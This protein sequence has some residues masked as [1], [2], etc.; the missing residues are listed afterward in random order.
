MKIVDILKQ[1][2]K[3]LSFEVF[4]PKRESSF[5]S[6][7]LATERIAK[8]RPAFMSVTYGA[9]GGVSQYTI[10][11]AKN[12]KEKYQ[13][14]MLA[15]LTCVA[16]SH[17]SVAQK[18]E[19]MYQAGI[20]N[21]MALRGDLT[22]DLMKQDPSK[23]EYTHAVELV[24]QLKESKHDFCIGGACYPEK[25]PESKSR[26]DDLKY[27]KEKADAG[28]DFFTTQ[29][30]FDNEIFYDFLNKATGAGIKI[31]ILPGIMPITSINQVEKS[32]K[33]SGSFMPKKL[34]TLVDKYGQNP[35]DMKRAGTEYALE[36]I[37]DLYDKGVK[38]VHVYSMNRVDIAEEIWT[39]LF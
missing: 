17:E 27:L 29:M 26:E 18:I 24:R 10:D 13:V 37:Q 7:C 34:L 38:N 36:Q 30:F 5:E 21:V 32:I 3:A 31:P 11:I 15:H 4:P 28:C 9:G 22:P 23:W 35:E 39:K 12:I 19:E 14:P 33:L 25:H 20:R 6:V 2:S 16:S 1:N 8:I